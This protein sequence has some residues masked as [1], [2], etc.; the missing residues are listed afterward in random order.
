[1]AATPLVVV[2]PVVQPSA[3]RLRLRATSR[4]PQA[5]WSYRDRVTI[6]WEA[7]GAVATAGATLVALW[8][9]V[10]AEVRASS[11]GRAADRRL[12]RQLDEQQQSRTS[13]FL[14]DVIRQLGDAYAQTL[15]YANM[16]QASLGKETIKLLLAALPPDYAT[17]LRYEF[18]SDLRPEHGKIWMSFAGPGQALSKPV[19]AVW[20]YRELGS[21]LIAAGGSSEVDIRESGSAAPPGPLGR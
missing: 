5:W 12:Q 16:P 19:P 15:A 3:D 8:L 18:T 6:N 10:R 21:N 11:D 17:L 13:N 7:I 20:V 1:M 14:V 2:R 4:R 9:G